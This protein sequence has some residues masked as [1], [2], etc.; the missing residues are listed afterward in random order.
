MYPENRGML[1]VFLFILFVCIWSVFVQTIDQI[2]LFNRIDSR[3]KK[4]NF[5]DNYHNPLRIAHNK[6]SMMNNLKNDSGITG[7]NN[8]GFDIDSFWYFN[9]NDESD[10]N[11]TNRINFS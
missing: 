7:T 5:L 2:H 9:N 10:N 4:Y 1:S 6:T 3:K 8:T 11:N